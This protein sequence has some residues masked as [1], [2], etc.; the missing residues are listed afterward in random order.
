MSCSTKRNFTPRPSTRPTWRRCRQGYS[1][2]FRHGLKSL[3]L[4]FYFGARMS[5]PKVAKLLRSGGNPRSPMGRC[6]NLLIKDQAAFHVE[7]AV[8]Y[9]KAGLAGPPLAASGRHGRTPGGWAER[10]L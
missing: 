2:Q 9:Y 10:V 3:A 6:L 8:L 4:V 5:E 7:K 1:G